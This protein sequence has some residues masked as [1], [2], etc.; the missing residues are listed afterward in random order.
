MK[1]QIQK[2]K[3]DAE[4]CFGVGNWKGFMFTFSQKGAKILSF[5]SERRISLHMFF[6]FFPLHALFLDS[7]MRVVD[8]KLLRPFTLY[9]S[10]SRAKYVVEVPFSLWKGLHMKRG[11]KIKFIR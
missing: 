8:Y 9:S 11:E 5:H 7:R 10:P 2:R 6:V 4:L 1:I 3:F